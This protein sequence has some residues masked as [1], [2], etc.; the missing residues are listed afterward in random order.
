MN[1]QDRAELK[2]NINS[3][4]ANAKAGN[5]RDP[6]A[7][8]VAIDLLSRCADLLDKPEPEVKCPKC[9][10]RGSFIIGQAKV[11]CFCQTE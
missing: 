4:L 5:L 1:K 9:A 3:I 7:M 10:G 6:V 2:L 11:L 8:E